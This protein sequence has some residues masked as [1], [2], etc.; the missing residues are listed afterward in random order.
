MYKDP[1][2]VA[3]R[4]KVHDAEEAEAAADRALYLARLAVKEV[5]DHLK[6]MEK[7]FADEWVVISIYSGLHCT[8]CQ[9]AER[10]V[11]K[12]SRQKRSPFPKAPEGLDDTENFK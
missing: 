2:I 8:H 6:N 12:P 7:E 3:A 1:S 11:P 9:F 5:R 4:Q 10:S